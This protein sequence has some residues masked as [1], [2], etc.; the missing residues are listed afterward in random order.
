MSYGQNGECLSAVFPK[1]QQTEFDPFWLP[2]SCPYLNFLTTDFVLHNL[3][4]YLVKFQNFWPHQTSVMLIM[5]TA[6]W[7]KN[8]DGQLFEKV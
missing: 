4:E 3:I 6:S 5:V 2:F 1:W 7:L 8:L